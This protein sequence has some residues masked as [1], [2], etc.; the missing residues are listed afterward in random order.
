M[1]GPSP[2]PCPYEKVMLL[3]NNGARRIEYGEYDKAISVL[4][5]ALEMT[6][7]H[8]Q[9]SRLGDSSKK[10]AFVEQC[11]LDKCILYSE[12][13]HHKSI[14][15]PH[16][17][18]ED[19]YIYFQPILVSSDDMGEGLV[20]VVLF[21]LALAHHLQAVASH[22]KQAKRENL[23]EKARLLYE[24]AYN[25]YRT[26]HCEDDL[27]H[28]SSSLLPHYSD[29]SIRFVLII[30]NNICQ[31]SRLV[32]NHQTYEVYKQHLLSSVMTVIKH[33]TRI[34]RQTILSNMG[35][36]LNNITSLVLG[37]KACAE[38]A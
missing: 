3:S 29:A 8:E 32:D 19:G 9:P 12:R 16:F 33:N 34:E 4:L 28:D 31:L 18:D 20:F 5:E 21:N 10:D 36:F 14:S 15:S 38:A 22:H 2:T 37:E 6:N 17:N 24:F 25:W 7:Q 27:Q 30:Q 11:T 1:S 35:G 13:Y 26:L 23:V